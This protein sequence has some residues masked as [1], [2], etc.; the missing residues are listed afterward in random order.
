MM[1]VDQVFYYP[2][3]NFKYL[4]SLNVQSIVILNLRFENSV[5]GSLGSVFLPSS[6]QWGDS[7]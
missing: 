4:I 5:S 1:F 6:Y 7:Y 2:M 3:L